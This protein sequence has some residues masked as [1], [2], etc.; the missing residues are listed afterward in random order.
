MSVRGAAFLGIGA[1]AENRSPCENGSP[2]RAGR[3]SCVLMVNA[4]CVTACTVGIG[5]TAAV[6]DRRRSPLSL[7][8]LLGAVE[9]AP[10]VAAA[11]VVGDALSEALG[12][13]HVSFLSARYELVRRV[14]GDRRESD[15]AGV[16]APLADRRRLST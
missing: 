13:R 7:N 16:G 9:A 2:R 14:A 10:P 15:G 6:T 1:R 11:E 3:S 12:A 4:S 5:E 8:V